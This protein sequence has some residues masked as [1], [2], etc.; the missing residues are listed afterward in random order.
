MS[1]DS[2]AKFRQELFDRHQTSMTSTL[3][4]VGDALPAVG[5][6][7]AILK[8]DARWV[9]RG[10]FVGLTAAS[11]AHLFQPGTLRAEYAA[12]LRHPLWAA[13]AER[14]RILTQRAR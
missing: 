1:A 12:I 14:E 9:G 7:V 4:T 3:S 2:Y 5:L 6:I 10:L 13:R 8:R 11:I